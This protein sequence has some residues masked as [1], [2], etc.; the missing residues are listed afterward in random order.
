MSE[1]FKLI[2]NKHTDNFAQVPV[3][4]INYLSGTESLYQPITVC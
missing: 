3:N 1:K 2:L 4:Q